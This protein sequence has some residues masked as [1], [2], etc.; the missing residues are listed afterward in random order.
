[1]VMP[2]A[3]RHIKAHQQPVPQGSV[4]GKFLTQGAAHQQIAGVGDQGDQSHLPIGGAGGD[5]GKA[6][7]LSGGGIVEQAGQQTLKGGESR[8]PGG[9]AQGKGHRKVAQ[10]DGDAVAHARP[11]SRAVSGK[12]IDILCS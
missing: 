11:E 6:R 3:H 12:A 7:V 4:R 10:G 5:Q 1:M 2:T 9:D 8:V